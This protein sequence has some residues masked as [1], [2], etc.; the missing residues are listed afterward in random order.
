[1]SSQFT[2][3]DLPAC[4]AVGCIAIV[5]TLISGKFRRSQGV[6]MVAVYIAYLLFT[7]LVLK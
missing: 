3:V 7:T 5:P 6:I 1:M 2:L 4:L